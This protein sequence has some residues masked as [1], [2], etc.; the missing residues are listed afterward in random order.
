MVYDRLILRERE[1]NPIRVA[2]IGAGHMGGGTVHQMS[3]MKGIEAS[4]IAELDVEKALAVFETNGFPRDTVLVTNNPADAE[5]AVMKGKPVVSEDGELAAQISSVDSVVEATGLPEVVAVTKKD[6]KAGE[7]LDG[8]GGYTVHGVIER[9]DVAR[10]E[11]LLP[12]GFAYDIPLVRDVP[13]DTPIAY[14]D[15]KV[16]TGTFL[17]KLRQL[18]DMN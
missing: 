14:G 9:A 3:R 5:D 6:L 18:Q 4:I 2:I 10:E 12:L 1:G 8:G 11:N 7:I 17:Y 16:D 15:V 13:K